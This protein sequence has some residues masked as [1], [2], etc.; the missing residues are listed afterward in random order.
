[1]HE[2]QYTPEEKSGPKAGWGHS[3][4][5]EAALTAREANVEILYISHHDPDS[6]PRAK[7]VRFDNLDIAPGHNVSMWS[8]PRTRTQVI[9]VSSP[10]D[11]TDSF[12]VSPAAVTGR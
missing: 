7:H 11:E 6:G 1:M 9:W 5:K 3:S 8:R 2:G 4:W 12:G 10:D